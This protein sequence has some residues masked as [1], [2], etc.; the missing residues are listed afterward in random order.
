MYD[1]FINTTKLQQ[2]PEGYERFVL[3]QGINFGLNKDLKNVK[4]II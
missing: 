2:N 1:W 4:N 3:E